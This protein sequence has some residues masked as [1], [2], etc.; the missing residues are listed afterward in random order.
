IANYFINHAKKSEKKIERI[1]K[2]KENISLFDS[3][4]EEENNN[5]D[6][7]FSILDL[8]ETAKSISFTEMEAIHG[9]GEK[10]AGFIYDWFNDG[11]NINL[12]E[13]LYRVGVVLDVKNITQKGKLS[14]KTFLITG[15]LSEMSRDEAHEFIKSKGGKISNS[16][17]KELDFLVVGESAGSK[18]EKAKS[19]NI[20][21]ITEDQLKKMAL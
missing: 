6:E 18:L 16:V 17:S 21:T 10:T 12:L 15:S 3:V 7:D 4:G 2:E 9:I 11:E 8:I 1:K 20:T 14:G 13:K 5:D 19:L